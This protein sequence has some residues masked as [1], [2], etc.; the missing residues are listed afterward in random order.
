MVTAEPNVYTLIDGMLKANGLLTGSFIKFL[1]ILPIR[2][3]MGE[4]VFTVSA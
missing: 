4:P 1:G 2:R 3:G